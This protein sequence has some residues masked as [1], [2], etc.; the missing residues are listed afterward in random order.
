MAEV[1]IVNKDS[2]GN[3]LPT[4]P[5]S[6]QFTQ[7]VNKFNSC[8]DIGSSI[9]SQKQEVGMINEVIPDNQSV[10]DKNLSVITEVDTPCNQSTN[11]PCIINRNTPIKD[12][13]KTQ[14]KRN[15]Y[16]SNMS[17]KSDDKKDVTC[18]VISPEKRSAGSL[19]SYSIEE[20]PQKI[21]KNMKD[22]Y[23]FK[24]GEKILVSNAEN[25]SPNEKNDLLNLKTQNKLKSSLNINLNPSPK[26]NPLKGLFKSPTNQNMDIQNDNQQ[27]MNLNPLLKALE[28]SILNNSTLTSGKNQISSFKSPTLGAQTR[29]TKVSNFDPKF[30]RSKTNIEASLESNKLDSDPQL[31]SA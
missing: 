13:N 11:T 14:G 8:E 29:N 12:D 28:S 20:T 31:V 19:S 3:V 1:K 9:P 24:N 21:D 2:N 15:A 30:K 16:I 7:V 25:E 4:K 6:R 22:N 17:I 26:T 18:R 5:M 23:L 10:N 27:E